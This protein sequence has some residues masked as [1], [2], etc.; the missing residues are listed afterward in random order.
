MNITYSTEKNFSCDQLYYLFLS[1][2]WADEKSTTA[3]KI[4]VFNLPFINST[5]VVSAWEN[6]KTCV[7]P[8]YIILFE[9]EPCFWGLG[10]EKSVDTFFFAETPQNRVFSVGVAVRCQALSAARR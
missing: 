8:K 6:D 4:S 9:C 3:E 1:V 10:Q 5:V 2:G 7:F